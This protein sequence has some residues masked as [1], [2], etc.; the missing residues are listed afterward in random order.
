[1]NGRVV[2]RRRRFSSAAAEP[3]V[4]VSMTTT[5]NSGQQRQLAPR[6]Q[7]FADVT[8]CGHRR[9]RRRRRYSTTRRCRSPAAARRRN[10]PSGTA[11]IHRGDRRRLLS[12]AATALHAAAENQSSSTATR[13]F[14]TRRRKGAY[15]DSGH[16]D[17]RET[18]SDA[19][20]TTFR[21][22][23]EEL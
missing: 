20:L 6:G 1:M 22:I 23:S 10:R 7:V 3:A 11:T 18:C 14:F 13:F 5:I 21:V 8:N 16:V 19:E 17:R 2:G 4:D 12:N 15:D 9:R